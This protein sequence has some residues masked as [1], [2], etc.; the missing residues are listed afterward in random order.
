MFENGFPMSLRDEVERVNSV[1]SED[2]YNGVSFRVSEGNSENEVYVL[3]DG[4][5]IS[6]PDRIYC[7]D[8]DDVY[9]GLSDAE[10][11][12]YDCIYTRH[13]DGR[14]REKHIRNILAGDVLVS[15]LIIFN[16]EPDSFRNYFDAV[17]WATVSLTTMGYGDI[18]P[19]TT[20]GRVV[21]MVSSIMGIAI[22]ALPAGII[23]SGF[24][25]ELQSQRKNGGEETAANE[26]EQ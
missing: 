23:T 21:T 20:A 11:L 14:V 1:M 22:I 25:D 17:Y 26:D 19:I 2:T 18:Y 7:L 9:S 5:R 15:A 6:F 16:V 12:I 10:K 24:M 13:C 3:S 8:D 4:T